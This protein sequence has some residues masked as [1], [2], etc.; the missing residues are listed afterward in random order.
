MRAVPG[1]N[2]P[3]PCGSGKKYKRCCAD[4][5][6]AAD[7]E[8]R[9]LATEVTK[10]AEAQYPGTIEASYRDFR[11]EYDGNVEADVEFIATWFLHEWKL[12]RGGTPLERYAESGTDDSLR[13]LADQLASAKL[14]LWRV[15][16][17]FPGKS[18]VIEPF[19]GGERAPIASTNISTVVGPWDLILGRLR[20]D[21]MELWG[22][23]RCYAASDEQGLRHLLERLARRLGIDPDDIEQIARRSPAELLHYR[24]PD[25]IL[26][27]TEG[28]PV[29]FVTARWKAAHTGARAAFES[30]GW[31]LA[32]PDSVPPSYDWFGAR[33][34]LEAMKPDTDTLPP[35]AVTLESSPLG[36]PDVLSLGTFYVDGDE[37]RYEGISDR[38]VEWAIEMLEDLLPT[39]ELVD[40]ET[41]DIES[42][43]SARRRRGHAS[44]WS[45][46]PTSRPSSA[47]A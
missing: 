39:A 5:G 37:I 23:S 7:R 13:A 35:G 3:C 27:T 44:R 30:A 6:A 28:D 14:N 34:K 10:W 18:L 41:T 22:P 45:W 26:L 11:G 15:I 38:R 2:D 42:R 47:R 43:S 36:M 21:A 46:R 31:L 24:A 19:S 4:L 20:A 40:V 1:R 12:P 25:P 16:E 29:V 17:V 32:D 33:E 8:H 9:R